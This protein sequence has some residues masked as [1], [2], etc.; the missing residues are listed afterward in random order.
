MIRSKTMLRY[1]TCSFTNQS[2]TRCILNV[3]KLRKLT[4]TITLRIRSMARLRQVLNE[5]RCYNLNNVNEETL[6]ERLKTLENSQTI[7]DNPVD[8]V[9]KVSR[10][11]SLR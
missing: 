6:S 7:D 9:V 11:S 1:T 2:L 8:E 4:R 5:R 10:D 3:E